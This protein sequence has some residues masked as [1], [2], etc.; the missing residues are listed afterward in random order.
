VLLYIYDVASCDEATQRDG[1]VGLVCPFVGIN[2]GLAQTVQGAIDAPMDNHDFQFVNAMPIRCTGL[3]L[4]HFAFNH[5]SNVDAP[6]SEDG[7]GT[8]CDSTSKLH[9]R[10]VCNLFLT[11]FGNRLRQVTRIHS[12]KYQCSYVCVYVDVCLR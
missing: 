8:Q 10:I 2:D 3:H 11:F 6:S 7:S 12:S 1:F 9:F 5:N 4:I